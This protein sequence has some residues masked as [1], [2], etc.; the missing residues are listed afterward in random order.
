MSL[1][2]FCRKTLATLRPDQSVQEAA[3]LMHQQHVGAVVV[4]DD[5]GR[6]TGLLTDRDIV[7]RVVT[8][9]HTPGDT[10]VSR[11]LSAPVD[12]CKASQRLDEALFLM[13]QRCVRRLPL[14]DEAGKL[15]GL[16]SLDDL[17][18]LVAGEL[19]LVADAVRLNKGP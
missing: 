2:R 5:E 9:G 10:P 17:V 18:V 12:L 3:Q 14:V 1:E 6:P 7:C 15:C 13:Q 4:V 19:L 11:V 8:K 16:V